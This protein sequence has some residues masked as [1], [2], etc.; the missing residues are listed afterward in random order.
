M[1]FREI[2]TKKVC[3]SPIIVIEGILLLA[4][5]EIRDLL[6]I[7][8]YIDTDDDIRLLRRIERD[9]TCRQR[10]FSSIKNQYLRTVKPMQDIFVKPSKKFA[11]FVVPGENNDIALDYIVAKLKSHLKAS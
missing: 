5:P 10:H 9:M 4:V 6:D 3:S 8:I 7:K 11:H 2:T 1:I